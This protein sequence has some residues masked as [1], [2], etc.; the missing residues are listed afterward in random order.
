MHATAVQEITQTAP[1]PLPPLPYEQNALEPSISGNTLSFHHGKHHNK[2]VSTTN[3]LVQGTQ[4]EQQ[5]LQDIIKATAGSSEHQK[6]FNNAAQSW[7]HWFYW[8]SMTPGGGGRP[9]G[10]IA[11]AIDSSFGGY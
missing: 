7:N 5:T 2:Y 1:F 9:S 6:L 4:F 3:Q 8:N 10:S 11:Q